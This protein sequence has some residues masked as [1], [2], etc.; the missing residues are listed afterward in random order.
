MPR[1]RATDTGQAM[2]QR[3]RPVR[4]FVLRKGRLTPAQARALE[5]LWPEYGIAPGS[6]QLDPARL[7]GRAAPLVV[8]IGFGDGEATWRMAL[9]E[10]GKDFIA[11]EVHEPGVGRL[12]QSL[13][14]HGIGNVRIARADA[15][16]FIRDRVAEGQLDE[17]RIYFPDPWPKKRHHKRRIVQPAFLDLLAARMKPAGILHVATDWQ[18]YAGHIL[19]TCDAHPAFR[20]LAGPGRCSPRPDWRP[21]T[22]YETRGDR[23]GHASFDLLYERCRE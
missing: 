2:H 7:F 21:A 13:A 19:E 15:V 9:R 16:E 5:E 3:H 4:S 11:I 12:L 22:K 10:P 17:V 14:S 20:N 6:G 18:P 8:E 1:Q 23:L